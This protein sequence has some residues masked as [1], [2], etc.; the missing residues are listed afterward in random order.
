MKPYTSG[1]KMQSRSQIF[2]LRMNL[3]IWAP[4]CLHSDQ[5]VTFKTQLLRK[6]AGVPEI[7]RARTTP[8]PPQAEGFS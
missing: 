4:L 2:Y 6:A 7:R 1:L 5:G 8:Y 3:T